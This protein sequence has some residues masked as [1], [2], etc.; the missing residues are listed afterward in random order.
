MTLEPCGLVRTLRLVVLWCFVLNPRR[1]PRTPNCVSSWR[2]HVTTRVTRVGGRGRA[3]RELPPA[4]AMR[5][6]AVWGLGTRW[7]HWLGIGAIGLVP[8]PQTQGGGGG[9][10]PWAVPVGIDNGG[11]VGIDK[12]PRQGASAPLGSERKHGLSTEQFPVSAYTGSS[13]NLKDLKERARAVVVG[14]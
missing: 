9:G 6:A 2:G 12:C 14:R 4:P 13:K 3:P 11:R 10:R 7:S 8:S 1:A 5:W